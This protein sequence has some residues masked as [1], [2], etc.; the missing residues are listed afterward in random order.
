[1]AQAE[2]AHATNFHNTEVHTLHHIYPSLQGK[3]LFVVET[4][5]T[6]RLID[7]EARGLQK[8]R[9]THEESE[10]IIDHK[11]VPLETFVD[12]NYA[13]FLVINPYTE[14]LPD[15]KK[16]IDAKKRVILITSSQSV[17]EPCNVAIQGWRDAGVPTVSKDN[18]SL[19]PQML[20][21]T[22]NTML[23]SA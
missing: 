1:M 16:I 6:G 21:Q 20:M 10:F 19:F 7:E 11:K 2:V 8:M 9:V 3:K 15:I 4:D 5:L 18:L 12:K 13:D 22:I 14:I 23:Q 17:D